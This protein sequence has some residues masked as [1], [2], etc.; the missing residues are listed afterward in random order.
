MSGETFLSN[1]NSVCKDPEVGRRLGNAG[2]GREASVAGANG[3]CTG[4]LRVSQKVSATMAKTFQ[5][6]VTQPHRFFNTITGLWREVWTVFIHSHAIYSHVHKM[7]HCHKYWRL[8]LRKNRFCHCLCR[9]FTL[10]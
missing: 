6:R 2:I 3:G 1:G 4:A 9:A 10:E 5:P 7:C 8:L